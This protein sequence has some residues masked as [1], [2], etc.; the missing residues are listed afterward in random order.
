MQLY[1][2][3]T[4]RPVHIEFSLHLLS[5]KHQSRCTWLKHAAV[6]RERRERERTWVDCLGACGQTAACAL[7]KECEASS[8]NLA[9]DEIGP[10]VK[11]QS[12]YPQ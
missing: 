3:A 2:L 12:P 11:I 10:W 7:E 9:A 5:M 1:N 6:N 4:V 8:F